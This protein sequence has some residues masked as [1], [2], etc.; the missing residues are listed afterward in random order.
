MTY[1]A[2]TGPLCLVTICLVSNQRCQQQASGVVLNKKAPFSWRHTSVFH[3]PSVSRYS[4]SL[5]GGRSGDQIPVG[6]EIFRIRPH[7]PWGPPS[8]LYNVYQVFPGG[9]AAGAW[10][11][12]P[13]PSNAE[14]KEGVE[15][16]LYSPF[17]PSW[18]VLGWPSLLSL[19]LLSVFLQHY[20]IFFQVC[21]T[22][23][24]YSIQLYIYPFLCL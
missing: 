3:G 16:Y 4:D 19:L 14:V 1:Y 20:L 18:L 21:I 9:K 17:G 23:L 15:L 2:A 7:R 24:C 22:L 13:T 8:H 5:L 12:P 6:G 10:R 11:W